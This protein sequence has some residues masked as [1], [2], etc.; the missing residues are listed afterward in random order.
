MR[1]EAIVA[2][3]IYYAACENVSASRLAFREQVEEPNYEQYDNEGVELMFG[4]S[5]GGALNQP[6]GACSTLARRLLAWPN[7]LQHRVSPFELADP[8]KPGRRAIVVAFLVDPYV[9]VL[10]TAAVPP[11]QREW[12]LMELR[13]MPRF[14]RLPRDCFDCIAQ[15]ITSGMSFADAAERRVRLMGER[16]QFVQ[17]SNAN[18]FE[19]SFSLCEH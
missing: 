12:L 19:R 16:S 14:F 4:L 7:T 10:S 3:A 9:K 8:S 13:A 1:D 6:L 5:D 18:W 15:H 2:S 11:Q 17:G